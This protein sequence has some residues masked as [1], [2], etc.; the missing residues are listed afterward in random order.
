[1]ELSVRSLNL[2]FHLLPRV[3]KDVSLSPTNLADSISDAAQLFAHEEVT[4]EESAEVYQAFQFSRTPRSNK[5][6]DYVPGGLDPSREDLEVHPDVDPTGVSMFASMFEYLLSQFTF[7]AKEISITVVHPGHS[8]F[9]FKVSELRYGKPTVG[10]DEST[11][12]IEISGVEIAHRDLGIL[13]SPASSQ[14][15]SGSL[16]SVRQEF[17]PASY[18]VGKSS[19]AASP[20]SPTPSSSLK[21]RSGSN[22]PAPSVDSSVPEHHSR[23]SSP[24]GSSASSLFQSALTTQGSGREFR[25]FEATVGGG[26]TKPDRSSRTAGDF[27]LSPADEPM[28]DGLFH[29]V[30]ASLITEPIVAH[31]T[32]STPPVSP[33]ASSQTHPAPHTESGTSRPD[34]LPPNLEISVSVGIVACALTA[35]QIGAI[36]D[37]ISVIGSHSCQSSQPSI[38]KNASPVAPPLS[39]LDQASLML[40]IRGLVLLLQ[41]VPASLTVSFD[42]A[43]DT[44]LNNFFAHPLSPPKTNH[45]YFRFVMDMLKADFSVSTTLEALTDETSLI[46][47]QL[48]EKSRVSRGVR[49]MTSSQFRFSVGDLSA[50]AFCIPNNAMA[51]PA[52]HDSFVLPILLT[53][54]FLFTQYSPEYC[55]PPTVERHSDISP[56]FI[57]KAF[58]PLPEFEILDWTSEDHRTSQA[59]LSLW[60]VKPP[61]GYRRT[62]RSRPGDSPI[63]PPVA[64]SPEVMA[65]ELSTNKPQPALSGQVLLSSPRDPDIGTDPESACSIHVNIIPLHVF[66]DMGSMAA[67]LDFLNIISIRHSSHGSSMMSSRSSD[68]DSEG[69]DREGAHRYASSGDVTPLSSPQR[70]SLQR[71]HQQ[72]LDDLN[73]SVDYLSGVS[74]PGGPSPRLRKSHGHTQVHICVTCPKFTC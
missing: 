15:E 9:R 59:K 61:P 38:S 60:R 48:P 63:S 16:S 46:P 69:E 65:E 35:A 33:K 72:E 39:L 12:T 47:G 11:R 24:S 57:R 64:S 29:R 13:G 26:D 19:G 37:I 40:R 71:I 3:A 18:Q 53:D 54:P 20:S 58:P 25:S 50:C 1:V 74:A 66:V 68:S 70:E 45:S 42:D 73:L 51:E 67:V 8:S 17:N 44:P 2:I 34:P 62:H 5:A 41:S 21:G 10:Y 28:K 27:P 7:S 22:Y 55:P 49:G 32:T 56:E 31:I 52:A 14:S 6:D 30:I 23:P 43:H 4:R 36:L